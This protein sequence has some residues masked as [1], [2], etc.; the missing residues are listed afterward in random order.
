MRP[1]GL[2]MLKSH[3]WFEGFQWD[4]KMDPPYNP[5]HDLQRR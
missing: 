4:F 1:G 5:T 2:D 3:A